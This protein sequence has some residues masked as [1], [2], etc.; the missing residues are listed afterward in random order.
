MIDE[1][2]MSMSKAAEF[3][4]N[5]KSRWADCCRFVV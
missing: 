5:V 2:A 1:M 4:Y 3:G